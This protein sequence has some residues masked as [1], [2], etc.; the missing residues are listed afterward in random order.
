MKKSENKEVE[1]FLRELKEFDAE[2]YTIVES[3]RQIVFGVYPKVA[4]RI[5]YG[6]IMFSLEKDFGGL[7]VSKNH[8]SFEF[9]NGYQFKDPKRVLEGA[10]KY[11][12]HVKLRSLS[13]VKDK[14]VTSFV[15]QAAH[16]E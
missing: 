6:G 4:E 12:R 10:G 16:T 15:S 5:M 9:S 8:V 1:K 7:F 2:K 3:A 13:D 14:D 11:R